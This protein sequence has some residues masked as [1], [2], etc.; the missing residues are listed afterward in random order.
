M[1]LYSLP[2]LYS[3]STLSLQNLC[4]VCFFAGLFLNH[5]EDLLF[6]RNP[7]LRLLRCAHLSVAHGSPRVQHF[8]S[9]EAT[10]CERILSV[11]ALLILRSSRF[12]AKND[13]QGPIGK[14]R[15]PSQVLPRC[16]PPHSSFSPQSLER[17]CNLCCSHNSAGI[18]WFLC[19]SESQGRL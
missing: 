11:N 1:Y 18:D 9:S 12:W 4:T 15:S 5:M 16:R 10:D 7:V 14:K 13:S 3:P 17:V 2:S 8:R 19:F 6:A